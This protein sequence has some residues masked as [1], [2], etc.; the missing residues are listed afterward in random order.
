MD[1]LS[2]LTCSSA[3]DMGADVSKLRR[4]DISIGGGV[5]AV[6]AYRRG[7]LK[8]YYKYSFRKRNGTK[9]I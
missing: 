6:V 2:I 7:K 8:S 1:F 4:N 9:K 5:A 3:L